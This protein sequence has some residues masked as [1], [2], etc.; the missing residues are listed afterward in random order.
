MNNR[1]AQ[2]EVMEQPVLTR[3]FDLA[4][5]T[6]LRVCKHQVL[7]RLI[8]MGNYRGGA[9][10]RCLLAF[11]VVHYLGGAVFQVLIRFERELAYLYRLKERMHK[12][13]LPR[14]GSL[15]KG[16]E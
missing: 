13:G 12:R 15:E 5:N 3:R 1:M 6:V 14:E 7:A 10:F 16:G 11:S 9:G 8:P 2:Q 4:G